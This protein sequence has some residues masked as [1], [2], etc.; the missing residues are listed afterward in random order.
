MEEDLLQFDL[1]DYNTGQINLK[2]NNFFLVSDCP[3]RPNPAMVVVLW[4]S[5]TA[6]CKTHFNK[7]LRARH[8][9]IQIEGAT[10]M[11]WKFGGPSPLFLVK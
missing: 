3:E 11:T 5:W 9:I 7:N 8:F 6:Y 4:L 10:V 2:N 1:Y